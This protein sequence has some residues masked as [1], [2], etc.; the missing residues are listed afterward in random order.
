MMMERESKS[1]W[2]GDFAT[3]K[4]GG[5]FVRAPGDIG[6]SKTEALSRLTSSPTLMHS[7]FPG[8]EF[9]I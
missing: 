7:I 5:P 2:L 8:N 4:P 9:G 1:A 3:L 6:K